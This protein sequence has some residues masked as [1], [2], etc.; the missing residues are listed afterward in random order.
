MK[1]KIFLFFSM[2]VFLITYNNNKADA[3]QV[4]NI[5][6]K[7][8]QGHCFETSDTVYYGKA[9]GTAPQEASQN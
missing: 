3:Q 6:C 4:I 2:F 8:S 7:G 1:Y 5:Q 9:Y